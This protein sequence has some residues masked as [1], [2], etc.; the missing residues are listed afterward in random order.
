MFIINQKIINTDGIEHLFFGYR[1]ETGF[2]EAEKRRLADESIGNELPSRIFIECALGN[3]LVDEFVDGIFRSETKQRHNLLIG[4]HAFVA[5]VKNENFIFIF[6][7]RHVIK[8]KTKIK[9]QN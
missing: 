9:E 6:E 5:S 3:E 7:C 8:E 4:R 2:D 1:R